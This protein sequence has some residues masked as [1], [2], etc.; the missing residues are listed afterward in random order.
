MAVANP[1]PIKTGG[2]TVAQHLNTICSDK[3]DLDS[4]TN[5]YKE[6]VFVPNLPI[7]IR[8]AKVIYQGATSGTVAGGSV[9]IGSSADDDLVSEST[10]FTDGATIGTEVE[11]T[12]ADPE[13]PADTP[14]VVTW[15]GVAATQA[16]EAKVQIDYAYNA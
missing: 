13:V 3:F 5:P 2:L 4:T 15:T 10:P 9:K 1:N 8:S 6:L 12:L 7:T 11:L 14:V 16:G